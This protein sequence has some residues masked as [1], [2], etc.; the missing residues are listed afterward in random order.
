[1]SSLFA[2][3][4]EPLFK[5]TYALQINKQN[6]STLPSKKSSNHS[7]FF[8]L[9]LYFRVSPLK[10]DFLC[11]MSHQTHQRRLVVVERQARYVFSLLCVRRFAFITIQQYTYF[12]NIF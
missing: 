4:K 7:S 8:S 1:M 6:I 3:T 11:Y 2:V 12:V 10:W 9:A 5:S